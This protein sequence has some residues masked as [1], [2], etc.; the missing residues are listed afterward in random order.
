MRKKVTP[1]MGGEL[2]LPVDLKD[3]LEKEAYPPGPES[4]ATSCGS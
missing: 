1:M 4:T 3:Q 2:L